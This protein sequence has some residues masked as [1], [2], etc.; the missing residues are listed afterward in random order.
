[1]LEST[2]A[3]LGALFLSALTLLIGACIVGSI[4]AALRAVS[5]GSATVQQR[6]VKRA[7]GFVLK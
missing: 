2:V 4:F 3:L 7:F 1:M 5:R 6:Q